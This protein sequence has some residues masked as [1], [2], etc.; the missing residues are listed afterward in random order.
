[1]QQQFVQYQVP[2]P[3]EQKP[4]V[5]VMS[6]PAPVPQNPGPLPVK[7]YDI[8]AAGG[9][10]TEMEGEGRKSFVEIGGTETLIRGEAHRPAE[11]GSNWDQKG[12]IN[13][14]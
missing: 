2:Q 1:M 12:Q 13:R 14:P 10:T 3:I 4:Q 5:Q 8:P 9:N 11:L 6:Q 7:N